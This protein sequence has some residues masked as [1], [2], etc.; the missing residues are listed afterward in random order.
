MNFKENETPEKLRGHY[1]TDSQLASFLTRW[2]LETQPNSILEPGCGDGIFIESIAHLLKKPNKLKSIIGFEIEPNEAEKAR[3]RYTALKGVKANIYTKDFLGWSLLNFFNKPLFDGVLGNPPFIRYQYLEDFIQERAEKIFNL[4]NLKFTKHTN[5]W[6][7]FVVSSIAM[8]RPGGRLAMV[9][10]SEILHVPHAESLRL[11]LTAQCSKILIFDPEELWFDNVLQGTVLLLTEKKINKN[12]DCRGVAIIP[13]KDRSF[14]NENANKY[15][16]KA[17]YVNGKILR[18][19]KWMRGLLTSHERN[20]LDAVSNNP[21]VF[22]FDQVAGVDVGIVTGANKFFLVS[23]SIVSEF[24]L[25]QWAYPMFGRSEHVRGLIYDK[26]NHNENRK[27]GLPTNFLWLKEEV[28]ELPASVRNYIQLGEK[29]ELHKRY[30]CRI[31]N[32]WYCVPSVYVSSV[33]MLKRCHY[34]PRLIYNKAKAFTTDTA[35]RI[36]TTRG[37]AI[38]K[39]VFA[40]VNS[41]TSLSSELEGRHY[42]GG[43]LELVPSEIE[44]VI[45]PMPKIAIDLRRLDHDFRKGV[46]PEELLINQD[47]LLL[48]AIGLSKQ[49]R[50]VLFSAWNRLRKRRQR[51]RNK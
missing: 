31:R 36:K 2:V 25:E 33:G 47:E 17:N 50:Q 27:L 26:K 51:V 29:Q 12:D 4:F 48:K 16:E 14:L 43:V 13:T 32:P 8:L 28:D 23:D 6:V 3:K 46:S 21:D 49:D 1:Y 45:I 15:F 38:E 22:L 42:G 41:L 30:K 39:L 18:G 34:F 9:V 44:R 24:G 11:F 20:I 37:I 19:K 5:A 10:P 40:F 7:P 35:Y